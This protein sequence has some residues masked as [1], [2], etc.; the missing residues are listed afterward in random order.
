M[1]S[2]YC[3][4]LP[5][6]IGY[7]IGKNFRAEIVRTLDRH[8]GLNTRFMPYSRTPAG[9]ARY[10]H[11]VALHRNRFPEF[12]G[13]LEGMAEGASVP[14]EKLFVI[15][16]RGEYQR[17]AADGDEGGCSTCS[18]VSP[19]TAAFGHNEDGL[20]LYRDQTYLVRARPQDK[21]VFTAFCYPGFLPG[22]AFGFNEAGI[23]FSCNN[24]QPLRA[25]DG[26][27]RHFIA[28]SLLES[29]SLPEAVA[30][31]HPPDRAYGFNYTIGSL[32]ER[33]IVNVEVTPD[34][35]AVSEIRG[36]YFHANHYVELDNVDQE[37]AESSRNRFE[38]GARHILEDRVKGKEDI[39]NVL[40]DVEGRLPILRDGSPPDPFVTLVTALFDLDGRKLVIYGGSENGT[41][42]GLKPLVELSLDF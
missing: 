39:L 23:C 15:N 26:V 3:E 21:P 5:R 22:N 28:R 29:R 25:R 37:I 18:L 8:D 11:L 24:V 7:T 32:M 34:D 35:V 10:R 41:D 6:E 17:Y 27:G 33:R 2:V 14:F 31:V 12:I 38:R 36:P 42:T 19:G 16:L 40:R 1:H 9:R 13:E 20:A 4:G 30:A